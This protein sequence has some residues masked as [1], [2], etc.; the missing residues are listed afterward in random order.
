MVRLVAADG[1]NGTV[2]WFAALPSAGFVCGSTLASGLVSAGLLVGDATDA[3]VLGA[4]RGLLSSCLGTA[5]WFFCLSCDEMIAGST[6]APFTVDAP[7][8]ARLAGGVYLFS[9][10]LGKGGKSCRLTPLYLFWV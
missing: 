5:D 2:D 10:L 6:G 4:G 3:S 7:V 8:G 9:R 1:L